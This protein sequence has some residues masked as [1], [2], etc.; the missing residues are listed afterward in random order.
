MWG[1]QCRRSPRG[2]GRQEALSATV[3]P[4]RV[5]APPTRRSSPAAQRSGLGP[6]SAGGSGAPAAPSRYLRARRRGPRITRRQR[7][8]PPTVPRALARG[9]DVRRRAVRSEGHGGGGG[10]VAGCGSA[11]EEALCRAASAREGGTGAGPGGRAPGGR[12]SRASSHPGG[13]VTR[14]HVSVCVWDFS[15]FLRQA[16]IA[17]NFPLRTTF[18]ASH[19]CWEDL[20]LSDFWSLALETINGCLTKHLEQLKAPEG[21]LPEALGNLHL[22]SS[23][24]EAA[25]TPG[26]IPGESPVPGTCRLKCVCYGIGN[27]ATCV[28]ARYQLTFLL[29][30]LEK[31][32]I[33]RRHCWVFDPLFS[34]LEITVLNTLGVTVLSENEVAG[35]DSTEKLF[36]HCK[37][38][39]R[40]GGASAA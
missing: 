40:T 20:L 23:P 30:F 15:C 22:D 14:C 6:H 11:E 4:L 34:Q 8:S 18:A 2:R 24:D 19:K 29:L 21:T 27:F 38:F 7:L 17:I 25:V 32:Q 16:C 10:T 9:D 33:P 37:D 3:P 39:R 5:P 36:L 35:Q 1:G 26:S 13:W 28:I 12:R 31:C